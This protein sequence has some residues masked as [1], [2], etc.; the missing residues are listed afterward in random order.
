MGGSL[1]IKPSS[2]VT[3]QLPPSITQLQ[4]CTMEDLES[5]SEL[6]NQLQVTWNHFQPGVGLK[7]LAKWGL[8]ICHDG[9]GHLFREKVLV[10]FF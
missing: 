4:S 3:S 6:I 7:H 8:N 2:S 5:E 10:F 9:L 1:L